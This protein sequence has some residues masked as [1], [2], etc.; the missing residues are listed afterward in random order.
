M[1]ARTHHHR[2]P[3]CVKSRTL[4]PDQTAQHPP[5]ARHARGM[6]SKCRRAPGAFQPSDPTIYPGHMRR[7]SKRSTGPT[8]SSPLR[9]SIT[10]RALPTRAVAIRPSTPSIYPG[11]IRR[12]SQ[13]SNGPTKSPP[14]RAPLTRR[15]SPTRAVA[16]RP[17]NPSIYPRH[18]R[19]SSKRSTG[20]TKSP[21]RGGAPAMRGGLRPLFRAAYK[22]AQTRHR[23][24]LKATLLKAVIDA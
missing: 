24:F 20:P 23:G 10:R 2:Q 22:T 19:R 12:R 11:H 3:R 15:V 14:L 8:K 21:P 9:T 1:R 5:P 13:R 6:L 18:V 16:I 4:P 17:S 7:R